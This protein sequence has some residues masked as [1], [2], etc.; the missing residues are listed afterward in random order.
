MSVRRAQQEIDSAEFAEWMAFYR[1]EPWGRDVED[2]P[3]ALVASTI[4]NV[5]RSAKRKPYKIDDFMLH[6]DRE[7]K[8]QDWR[9]QADMLRNLTIA[10]GGKVH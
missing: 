8:P 9:E 3:A 4:A 5:N 10:L 2:R 6:Y 1:L 7:H